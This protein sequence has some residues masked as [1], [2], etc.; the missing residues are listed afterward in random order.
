MGIQKLDED[1]F[2]N[3]VKIPLA[4]AV[5]LVLTGKIIDAKSCVAILL[6]DRMEKEIV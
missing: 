2:I 3:T 4:E 6:A 1:E 5:D